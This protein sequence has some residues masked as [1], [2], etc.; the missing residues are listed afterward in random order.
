MIGYFALGILLYILKHKV[1]AFAS[2][3]AFLMMLSF[4]VPYIK[5][6]NHTLDG[7][8][9]ITIA[10][11][12][13]LRTNK[14]HDV[15][16]ENAIESNADFI[17]FQE[18]DDQW[19]EVLVNGLSSQYPYQHITGI[20]VGCMGMAVFSKYPLDNIQTVYWDG[21]PNITGDLV[22]N[23]EKVHF[24]ASHTFSPISYNSFVKRNNHIKRLSEYLENK[25][26][27]VLAIGDYNAV[28]WDK[29][30]VAF[31]DKSKLNDSRKSLTPTFPSWSI[32]GLPI[33]Y[34]FHSDNLCCLDFSAISNTGSDHKGIIG[35]YK[36]N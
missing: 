14:N 7:N 15:L 25:K 2:I 28:P 12:N 35:H 21:V 32:T 33:D 8:A 34:I 17:S 10:H 31:R 6:G 24:I 18:V 22:L 19:A 5:F 30:I 1:L 20:N 16:L 29:N 9:D 23:Q 11:F 26:G 27:N 4:M 36:F 3:F 13:V